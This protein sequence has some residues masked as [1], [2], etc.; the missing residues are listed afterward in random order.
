MGGRYR[1]LTV[2]RRGK[3]IPSFLHISFR[4]AKIFGETKFQ[5]QEFSR[6]GSKAIEL[7]KEEE[8]EENQ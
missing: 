8:E 4:Y 5:P 1:T 7:E 2:K 3:K 6:S